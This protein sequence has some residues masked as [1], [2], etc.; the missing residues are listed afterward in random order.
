MNFD[1]MLALYLA[2][3]AYVNAEIKN[4]GR[5]SPLIAKSRESRVQHF[6]DS[7]A[8]MSRDIVDSA[9]ALEEMAKETPA[10]SK[11]QRDTMASA[12]STYMQ[13]A[14]VAN[15]GSGT[16]MQNHPNIAGALTESLWSVLFDAH[17]S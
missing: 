14:D 17:L 16:K 11:E 4:L 13:G 5:D 15:V 9:N 3:V 10:F 1:I 12:V 8:S 6:L 2:S 7:L